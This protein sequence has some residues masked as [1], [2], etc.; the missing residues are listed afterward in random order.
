MSGINRALLTN[1]SKSKIYFSAQDKCVFISHQKKDTT[2]SKKI[3]DYIMS[4]NIDVYFDEY[5]T[6]LRL[7]RQTNNPD[8]VVS[9][10]KKGINISTHMLCIISVNT[11]DS[12]WVPWEL[13]YGY[14]KTTQSVLTL[15]GIVDNQLPDYLKTTNILRGT[16]TLNTFIQNVSGHPYLIIENYTKPMHTLDNILDW[17][18]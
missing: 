11:L 1:E 14:D 13:G 6:D 2:I 10:I 4:Y 7:Y 12:K 16:K 9:C 8:G 15:K 3:A 5:D 18:L 17:S